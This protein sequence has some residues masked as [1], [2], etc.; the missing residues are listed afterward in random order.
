M[1]T[2]YLKLTLR[3]LARNKLYS[4][5]NIFG[6]SVGILCAVLILL[7]ITDELSY[8]KHHKQHRN[9]YRLESSINLTDKS[10]KVPAVPFLLGE[11][12][13]DEYPEIKEVVRFGFAPIS[14][15]RYKDK[16]LSGLGVMLLADETVFDIFTHTFLSGTPEGALDQ[17]GDLVV[18]ETAARRIFGDE[19]PMGKTIRTDTGLDFQVSAVLADPPDNDSFRFEV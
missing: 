7:Y 5:I 11:A 4:I 17:P 12:L 14:R 8:D 16:V 9:I 1:F 3:N 15:A 19:N 2:S 10:L 13:K 18:T 6:L